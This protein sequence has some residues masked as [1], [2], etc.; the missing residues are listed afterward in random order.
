[1]PKKKDKKKTKKKAKK[2]GKTV[3]ASKK[4]R[5]A[6]K[7]AKKSAKKNPLRALARRIVD[8]TDTNDEKALLDLYSANVESKEMN[9]PPVVGLDGLR[10]KLEGWS[11][12]ASDPQFTATSVWVDGNTIVIE[13]VGEVTLKANGKR[14]QLREIAVHEIED[15]KIA[16]ERYYYDPAAL[17][18]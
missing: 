16:R 15:G 5:A 7:G 2:A 6:K 10:A 9:M 17:Q 11:N 13:W 8:V 1:M 18:P 3:K 14:A 12:M 4:A